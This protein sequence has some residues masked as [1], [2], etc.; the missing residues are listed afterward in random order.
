MAITL[1]QIG[2]DIDTV[3][4]S[5]S[6][7]ANDR[8]TYI[9]IWQQEDWI[10]LDDAW[11]RG[12]ISSYS[13][14]LGNNGVIAVVPDSASIASGH[15]LW[16]FYVANVKDGVTTETSEVLY[17]VLGFEYDGEAEKYAGGEVDI[18]IN[19]LQ[20]INRFGEKLS[21]FIAKNDETEYYPLGD[22]RPGD[23]IFA[24]YIVLPAQNILAAA[25]SCSTAKLSNRADIISMMNNI[26]DNVRS[27]SE[28]KAEYFNDLKD[29][30]NNFYMSV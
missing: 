18:T 27:G 23:V 17:T 28:F 13:T 1:R 11:K 10:A 16:A 5:V 26:V 21:Y 4:F 22:V 24:D 25:K 3:R 30:I 12:Y 20:N 15:K 2:G 7:I 6:G 19:D 8:Q 9:W 14:A 29:C